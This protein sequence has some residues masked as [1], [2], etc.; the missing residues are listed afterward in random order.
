MK[1]PC[2]VR[3]DRAKL[4]HKFIVYISDDSRLS[5]STMS[6]IL[7]SRQLDCTTTWATV[8]M[9]VMFLRLQGISAV[10]LSHR[11]RIIV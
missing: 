11:I 4:D 6:V 10:V 5:E 8:Q 2:F 9:S 1:I 3:T 7:G